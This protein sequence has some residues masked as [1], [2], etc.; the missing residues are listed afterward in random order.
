MAEQE[1]RKAGYKR[2]K[3]KNNTRKV[4]WKN[5]KPH[6]NKSRKNMKT[7]YGSKCFLE[8]KTLKYP[9]CNKF[10]GKQECMGLYAADYYLNLNIGKLN[11]KINSNKKNVYTKK[12][13]KYNKLKSKS[14]RLKKRLC[15]K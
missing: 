15:K 2:I 4:K 10:N 7:K 11:K 14:D 8:P 13:K 3:G 5:I 9:I 6:S 12:L 1:R